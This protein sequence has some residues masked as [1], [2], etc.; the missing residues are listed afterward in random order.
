MVFLRCYIDQ[1]T[2][3]GYYT[4]FNLAF[5]AIDKALQPK[6]KVFTWQHLHKSGL[7]AIIADMC[8]KQAKG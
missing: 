8:V 7:H 3:H 4:L 1:E 2:D 6:G 5:E